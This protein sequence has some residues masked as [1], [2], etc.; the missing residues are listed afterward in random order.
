MRA[1]VFKDPG[2]VELSEVPR[3]AL[4]EPS[5]A[6]LRVTT[7]GLCGTDLHLLRREMPMQDGEVLGH[8]FV[9]VVEEAGPAVRRFRPGDRAVACMFASCGACYYCLKGW[10]V[11][12][13][14]LQQF[15]C[16]SWTRSPGGGQAEMVRVPFADRTLEP[17][18]DSL[19]D[20]EA[21]FVGDILATAMFGAE[22]AQIAPGDSVAVIG[23]GP[24]G[25]LAVQCARL[26]GPA[27]VY[28]VDMVDARLELAREL[29]AIPVDARLR[30]PVEA[31]KAETKDRGV[32][33]SIECVGTPAAVE[34]AVDCVRAGGTVSAV[35][36]PSVV[37][38]DFPYMM[39][40]LKDLTFR[41]GFCNVR[42][43]M[44]PLLD[45]VEARRL[46]PAR[47][48]SHRM[49]LDEGPEA[50]RLFE[51]KEAVKVLLCP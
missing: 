24:V 9:G 11:Q 7:A 42:P 5:D 48:V 46:E 12:C 38:A 13:E 16:G 45:L 39:A 14:H 49:A 41:A 32:D 35:G 37:S 2:R 50:Y 40:W 28:A 6:V 15:G 19:A 27:R 21:I 17:V 10:A 36:Y 47:I 33:A 20:E 30:H 25:L 44:R 22:R 26:L 3:P 43:Y 29:G 51:E 34:T 18:P 8:E 23:A 4:Q 31:L 1:L